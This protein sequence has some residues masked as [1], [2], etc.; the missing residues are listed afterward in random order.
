VREVVATALQGL[1]RDGMIAIRRGAVVL[2]DPERL[3]READAGLG[4]GA[5]IK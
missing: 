1:K 5:A 4:F 2:L 3:G